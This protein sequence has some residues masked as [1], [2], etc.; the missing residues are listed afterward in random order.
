MLF[1]SNL[2]LYAY[3]PLVLL[4]FH[5]Y[6]WS[7]ATKNIILLISSLAF[8]F[9]GEDIHILALLGSVGLNFWMG[10][11][12]DAEENKRK[13]LRWGIIGNLVILFVFKYTN[14]FIENINYVLAPLGIQP[15]GEVEIHLPIGI[16][17]FTFQ[18]ISYIVDVYYKSIQ[19]EK[20][21]AN[22]CL[23]IS[24]FPH[25]IAGP[26]V[27]YKDI[28]DQ[29]VDRVI[30]NERIASGIRRF[31]VG[32]F[33]KVVI[34]DNIAYYV[35]NLLPSSATEP[36]LPFFIAW[37][38]MILYGLQIYYDFSGYSDMAIG[39]ARMFGFHF[40]ENFNH[41]YI[42][43][44][45][46]DFWR[47]WHISL[48]QWF[49]DYVYIPLGGS[50]VT[51]GRLY[52]NIIIVFLLTGFW[53]GASWNFVL[54]GAMHGVF[55][56]M[57]RSALFEK[58]YPCLPNPIKHTYTLAVVLIGWVLFRTESMAVAQNII[59]SMF[60]FSGELTAGHAKASVYLTLE[61]WCV[62]VI[63]LALCIP[64][65]QTLITFISKHTQGIS[66]KAMVMVYQVI[67][68]GCLILSMAYMAQN[69]HSPFIYFRF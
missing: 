23:Y 66:A 21:F 14:F 20:K 55:L 8:Y 16:S 24:L 69:T 62:I 58:Y 34:A 19:P 35:D 29:I 42:A 54:W 5:A 39:L 49:R 13:Y 44:S 50:R 64:I 4:L 43:T 65:R 9:W 38:T 67:L 53:H 26:I 12:I 22:L 57:E 60:G 45:V 46:Q 30:N 61:L 56:I 17:F 31:I 41:P 37:G 2:F 52:F 40:N 7:L 48:S 63:G 47:R 32:L 36:N 1:N 11:K 68:L 6:N 15:L 25:Q 27:R 33:K 28:K 3:L 59:A 18:G 10:L 51:R